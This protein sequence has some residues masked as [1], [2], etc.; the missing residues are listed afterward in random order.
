MRSVTIRLTVIFFIL[1]T[2]ACARRKKPD[3]AP[4]PAAPTP[5]HA[6]QTKPEP[7]TATTSAPTEIEAHSEP[8]PQERFD[9]QKLLT[10]YFDFDDATLTEPMQRRLQANADYLK[11][12]PG[13]HIV[14]EGHC[15]ERGSAQ[16]N[17][18]LGAQRA[19]SV[20]KFLERLGVAS[21]RMRII[22][23]GKERPAMP[24]HHAAAWEKN[25]RSQFTAQDDATK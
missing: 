21:Q 8:V 12:H 17:L 24:A 11:K 6:A 13:T 25:R 15:D 14:V 7:V 4:L 16:Y 18:G 1:C 10:V 9:P 2:T 3:A 22:S 5:S 20:K 23:Y 19:Q